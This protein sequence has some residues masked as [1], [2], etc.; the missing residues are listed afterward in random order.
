M[1]LVFAVT[2]ANGSIAG[3]ANEVA[4]AVVGPA[5]LQLRALDSDGFDEST[6]AHVERLPG[7]KQAAPLLEQTATIIGPHSRSITVDLA[8]TDVSLAILNGLA[9]T[10][11]IAALSPGGIGLSK[12]AASVLGVDLQ[13]AGG[14]NID[15]ALKLRGRTWQLKLA[16]VL[17]P[18][19]FGALSRAQVAV[20]P[21]RR[22]QQLAGLPGRIT[23]ILV[24]AKPGREAIVRR[25]L[26]AVAAGRLVVAPADQD[27]VLLRQALRPSNQ[28]TQFFAVISAL[29]GFLFAFNAMLLTVPERRQAIANLRLAG[30]KRTAIVQLISFQALCLGVAASL[31]GLLAGYALS[32][33]AFHQSPGYLAQ[34]FTLG[35]NTVI[36]VQPLVVALAGGVTATFLASAIPLLDLRR[37]RALDAIYSENGVPGNA[38]GRRARRR[39]F[40]AALG[41]A[42][43]A[44]ALFVLDPS[45]ALLACLFLA[46]A[47]VLA[48]PLVF[49]AVLEAARALAARADKL[50]I[51]PIALASLKATTLRSLALVITGAIAIFGSVALGGARNDLLRGLRNFAVAYTA[52]A[53][54]WVLNPRDTAGAI[55]FA[56]GPYVS[57]MANI[58][59][60]TRV[61]VYQ[62]QFM[63]I[64]NRRVWVIARPSAAG[65]ALLK[66]QIVSGNPTSTMT[67]L[68][69]GGWVAVSKKIAEEGNVRLGGSFSLP[70]PTGVAKF[71][72]AATTTNFG[73]AAGAVVMDTTDYS[74]FWATSQ[75]TAL[76][77]TLKPGTNVEGVRRSINAVLGPNSGLETLTASARTS[78]FDALAGEGLS[79][80]GDISTL[81]VVAAIMAMAAALGSNIWQR[82]VPL[83]GLRL[84]GAKPPRLRRILLVESSLMLSAGCIAGA[85]AGIYGQIVIDGYLVH[86][87]GFPVATLAAGWRPLEIL[88]LVVLAVLAVVAIPG[89]VASRVPAALALEE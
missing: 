68:R 26:G 66:S 82:R 60:V 3:S 51:L 33:G 48:V 45:L 79:R 1:A 18:E 59:G 52:D 23:R 24:E 28:A 88:G 69:E 49:T 63:N 47:T 83:A 53:D 31:V 16:A 4:H 41:L 43:L 12:A 19:A 15:I 38:L 61:G 64:G 6:L 50:T 35:T 11:P 29:L 77:V 30:A 32:R 14:A 76:G 9:H 67:R 40:T 74:R 89:W 22:L 46:L 71:R 85:A 25:E 7:V 44:T 70:T 36:G 86:V 17:G 39:L 87:T 37:G 56:P 75:P 13:N 20:M 57:R 54:I 72:L 10:L 27:V 65:S 55:S 81:L 58:P 84:S 21:L 42:T 80:L 62:S 34:A 2:V 78:R 5:T 73:W 8:G